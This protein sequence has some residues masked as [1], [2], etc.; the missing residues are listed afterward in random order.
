MKNFICLRADCPYYV[1]S[2]DKERTAVKF[3]RSTSKAMSFDTSTWEGKCDSDFTFTLVESVKNKLLSL[4][5]YKDILS[6]IRSGE[7]ITFIMSE[8]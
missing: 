3:T 4:K 7:E 1:Q 8:K 5:S 6:K 2:I